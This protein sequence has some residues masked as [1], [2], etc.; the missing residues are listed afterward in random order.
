M[1]FDEFVNKTLVT[2]HQMLTVFVYIKQ[3]SANCKS[4]TR[5]QVFILSETRR[6]KENSAARDHVNTARRT[7]RF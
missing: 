3:G 2:E 5:E 6:S 4:A 1:I 7:K